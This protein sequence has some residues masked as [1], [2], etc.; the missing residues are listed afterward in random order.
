MKLWSKHLD[1]QY[2]KQNIRI[3][4]RTASIARGADGEPR[5]KEPS[6]TGPDRPPERGGEALHYALILT[7]ILVMIIL[8][9]KGIFTLEGELQ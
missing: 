9:I 1:P 3:V 6:M 7:L 5:R 4:P 8:L 2:R